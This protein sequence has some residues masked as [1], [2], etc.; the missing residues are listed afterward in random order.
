M[1][2]GGD[3][4]DLRIENEKLGRSESCEDGRRRMGKET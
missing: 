1:A 3:K 2:E 4:D